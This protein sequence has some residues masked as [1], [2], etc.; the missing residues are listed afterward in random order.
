MKSPEVFGTAADSLRPVHCQN[1]AGSHPALP[2]AIA[3]R[4]MAAAEWMEYWKWISLVRGLSP[5]SDGSVFALLGLLAEA[6]HWTGK[7]RY[8]GP[9]IIVM[10]STDRMS[11]QQ[12]VSAIASWWAL[13]CR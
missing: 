4:Q 11:G 1:N 8:A 2:C 6:W 9:F 3:L 7:V 5:T 13:F 12:S 10:R